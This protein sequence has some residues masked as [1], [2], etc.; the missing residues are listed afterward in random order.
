MIALQIAELI[1]VDGAQA[2]RLPDGFEFH[3][4]GVSIRKAGE[5]VILEPIRPKTWPANFFEEIR[6]DDP[7][8]VRP[9]QGSMSTAP[10][11]E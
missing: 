11:L 2:V 5:A 1:S 4:P 7:A 6:I 10:S 3:G 8:F 9:D